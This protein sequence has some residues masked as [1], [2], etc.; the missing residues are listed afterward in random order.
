MNPQ[1][2][3]AVSTLMSVGSATLATAHPT[4][5]IQ[6]RRSQPNERE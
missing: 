3:R 4:R 5:L 2:C 6:T 1:N